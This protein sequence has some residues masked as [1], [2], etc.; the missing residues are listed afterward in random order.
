MSEMAFGESLRQTL[1]GRLQLRF[2]LLSQRTISAA[3]PRRI[4]KLSRIALAGGNTQNNGSL[5]ECDEFCQRLHFHLFH[6]SLTMGL[7]GSLGGTEGIA[8]LLVGLAAHDE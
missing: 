1:S 2:C 8:D 3:K 6:H 7:D 5:G 4:R